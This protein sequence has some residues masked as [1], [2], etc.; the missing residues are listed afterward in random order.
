MLTT[1]HVLCEVFKLRE[2][3]ALSRNKEGFTRNSLEVLTGEVVR[4][5]PCPIANLCRE[6]DFRELICRDGLTDAGLMFVTAKNSA[7]VLT[8]DRRLFSSYSENSGYEIELLDNYLQQ[9][10]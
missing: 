2:S 5:L 8:D 10:D 9:T 6:D 3:S 1:A 4:E 7:L